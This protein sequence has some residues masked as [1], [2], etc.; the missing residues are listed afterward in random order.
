M[1]QMSKQQSNFRETDVKRAVRAVTN[2][3]LKIGRVELQKGKIIIIP[4]TTENEPSAN[5]WIIDEQ[6]HN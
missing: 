6:T 3:G 2:A 4:G 1:R 5:E